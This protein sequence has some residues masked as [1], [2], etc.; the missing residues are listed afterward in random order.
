M[1][2]SLLLKQKFF[3]A[4]F[5]DHTHF[6]TVRQ[7]SQDFILDLAATIPFGSCLI[8][9]SYKLQTERWDRQTWLWFIRTHI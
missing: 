4:F 5:E 8:C 1:I 2:L 9:G 7:Y 3:L 6:S